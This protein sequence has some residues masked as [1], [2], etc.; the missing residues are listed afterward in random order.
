LK[1]LGKVRLLAL[2]AVLLGGAAG[3]P[4]SAAATAVW[5]AE[6]HGQSRHEGL[7]HWINFVI[8]IAGL[9]YILRKPL[10][11]FFSERLGAIHHGLEEGRRA[12]QDSQTRLAGVEEKLANIEREIADFRASSAREMEAERQRL[13][14]AAEREGERI[15]EFARAR[16]E[17]A[18]RAAKL[19][20][21]RYATGQAV[22]L[23]ETLV[24]ERLDESARRRLLNRFVSELDGTQ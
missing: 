10:S 15:L 21:R 24:R 17:A 6:A 23:A 22:A 18:A 2:F 14:Q 8:L 9:A 12:L 3:A 19:D 4:A 7:F 20:L 1:P 11:T 5:L 13:N 16:I